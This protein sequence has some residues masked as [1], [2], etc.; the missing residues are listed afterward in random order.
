LSISLVVGVIGIGEGLINVVF[1]AW[2]QTVTR[3]DMLG[4]VMSLVM[5]A[6]AG[7]QPVSLVLAGILV[8]LN[9]TLMFAGAG[10]LTVLTSFYLAA[11]KSVR[12]I[13]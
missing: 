1:I 6:S 5:F 10:G 11:S 4:R 12:N 2:F 7:M 3:E 8:D 9:P 13:N